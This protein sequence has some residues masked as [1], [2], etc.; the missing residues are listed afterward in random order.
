MTRL[1]QPRAHE[2]LRHSCPPRIGVEFCATRGCF[3][4]LLQPV[5]QERGKA[6]FCRGLPPVSLRFSLYLRAKSKA[7]KSSTTANLG[8]CCSHSEINSW[9]YPKATTSLP[10]C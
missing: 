9:R 3:C 8:P 1:L 4:D 6:R 10:A 5:M 7:G 2:A